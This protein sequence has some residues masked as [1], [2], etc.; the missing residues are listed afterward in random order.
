MKKLFTLLALLTCF[1]GAN[2][3]EKVDVDLDFSTQTTLWGWGHGWVDG[4]YS[5]EDSPFDLEDGCLHYHSEEATGNNYDIQLQPFPGVS[6]LDASYT[7]EIT[8]KGTPQ[9]D[10]TQIWLSFSGSSTPGWVDVPADFQTLTYYDNV[11]NPDDQ[12]F[13][14]SGSILLQCGHWVGDFWIKSI[15]I[16]HDEKVQE[17]EWENILVNGDASA[18]WANPDAQT[19]DNKYDGEGAELVSAYGKE[20]GYNNNNPHAALIEDGVFVCKT[21]P[22]D[23]VIVWEEDGEQWGQKHSAGDPKPDNTWQNQFWI[24]YP[25][26]L[27]DGEPVKLSFRYKASKDA[28]V[29][30]QDHRAPGDYVGGGKVGELN[31]TTEWQTYEADCL[32]TAFSLDVPVADACADLAEKMNGV[33]AAE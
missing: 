10:Q 5:A 2:A 27:A 26:P 32:K 7:I 20:Y 29:T 31:F 4:K 25:R 9:T 28:R 16:T 15:K 21:Q 23:P 33:L 1:L 13:K 11:N 17:V 22:V 18:A 24:N 8:L 19:V 12:Y 30:T 14:N 3:I 6:D